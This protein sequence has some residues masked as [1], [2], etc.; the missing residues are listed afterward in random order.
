MTSR[1]FLWIVVPAAVALLLDVIVG[2]IEICKTNRPDDLW[3][4]MDI[5]KTNSNKT[6]LIS[7]RQLNW[8]N[9]RDHCQS[10]GANLAKLADEQVNQDL[11]DY[12]MK[13]LWGDEDVFYDSRYLYYWIGGYKNNGTW[14]WVSD[15]SS[16]LD[17]PHSFNTGTPKNQST[18]AC[19]EILSYS[20]G[21]L[22]WND[23]YCSIKR[24]FICEIIEEKEVETVTVDE[25]EEIDYK[26]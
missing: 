12:F 22:L 5:C 7:Y 14:L 18:E 15:N 6:L 16:I 20:N 9:S 4:N 10:M 19:V 25:E 24:P 11:F 13:R 23:G 21:K 1:S 3:K 26:D 2:Q 8:E 17:Q